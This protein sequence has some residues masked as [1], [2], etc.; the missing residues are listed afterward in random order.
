[1]LLFYDEHASYLFLREV[2][3]AYTMNL[4]KN[5]PIREKKD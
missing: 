5:D 4:L 3:H 1:M 2:W